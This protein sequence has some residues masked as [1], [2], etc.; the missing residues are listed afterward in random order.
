MAVVGRPLTPGSLAGVSR[1]T[2]RRTARRTSYRVGTSVYALPGGCTTVVT[3]DVTYH[4]CGGVYYRPQY[5]GSDVVY[6]VVDAP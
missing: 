2:A 6:V 4:N 3:A 1:R 5:H